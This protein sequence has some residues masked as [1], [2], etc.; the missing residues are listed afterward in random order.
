MKHV[1]LIVTHIGSGLSGLSQ[2]LATHSRIEMFS[3][4]TRYD[5]P[6]QL[7]WLYSHAHKLDSAAAIYADQLFYN[8]QFSCKALY[9]ACKFIYV[10]RDAKSS[11]NQ[12]VSELQYT[13]SKAVM[14]YTFRLRRICEMARCTPGAVLL[15]WND[16]ATGSGLPL[17]EEYLQLRT[18]LL[19]QNDLF[20]P[21]ALD[22]IPL[23]IERQGQESY[24]RHLYYLRQLPLKSNF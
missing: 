13:P 10:V 22:E 16:M 14:Y 11:L 12:I 3:S 8:I 5:H 7:E 4:K 2:I 21:N 9:N 17:I 1:L 20:V 19:K 6:I 23:E 24:E 15:T 18:P